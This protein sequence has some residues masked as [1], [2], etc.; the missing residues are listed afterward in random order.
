MAQMTT[1]AS[2]SSQ[3]RFRPRLRP[4]LNVNPL[5]LR[6]YFLRLPLFTRGVVLVILLFWA[7]EL[8]TVWSVT[9]WGG[10]IPKE[11]G[12]AS[13][14]FPQFRLSQIHQNHI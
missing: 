14:T 1:P 6:S 10:L 3:Q 5:R 12:W 7:L 8:Q 2:S 13:C 11:V 4:L 9:Q